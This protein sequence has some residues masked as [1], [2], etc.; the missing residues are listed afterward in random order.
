MLQFIFL[1]LVIWFFIRYFRSESS[2]PTVSAERV[3]K[4]SRKSK[5]DK[6]VIP[7]FSV[8]LVS[9]Q[10]N[11]K[12]IEPEIQSMSSEYKFLILVVNDSNVSENISSPY[13][14][15][16]LK[17]IQER[18]ENPELKHCKKIVIINTLD[19]FKTALEETMKTTLSN[20][21]DSIISCVFSAEVIKFWCENQYIW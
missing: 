16:T 15:R 9:N 8:V 17:L 1:F 13:T 7:K 10:E 21:P 2:P 5:I 12:R 14:K 4:I 6:K 20:Q 11:F 19:D 3:K 18:F